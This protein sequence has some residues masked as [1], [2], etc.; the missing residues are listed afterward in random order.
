[1]SDIEGLRSLFTTL[2]ERAAKGAPLEPTDRK[3]LED[4]FAELEAELEEARERIA[5]EGDPASAELA[6]VTSQLE[7]ARTRITQLET[8]TFEEHARAEEAIHM[9]AQARSEIDRLN[10]ELQ[11]AL[12]AATKPETDKQGEEDPEVVAARELAAEEKADA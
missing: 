6:T 4:H 11:A 10:G 8:E 3:A 2:R 5:A 7:T 9:L 1:M 12:E